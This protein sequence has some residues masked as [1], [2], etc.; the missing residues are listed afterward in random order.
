[1]ENV[2]VLMSTYNG[3][4][5]IE[6]QI[7]SILKQKDVNVFLYV[8]DDGSSDATKSILDRY[9]SE[10]KLKWYTGK[11]LKSSK[12]FM[13]LIYSVPLDSEFYALSDQDDFWLED[14]L[15]VAIKKIKSYPKDEPCLYYGKTLLVD[16]NLKRIEQ[17]PTSYVAK[18]MRQAI[19]SS[20][21]TG[22]TACFNRKLID[23]LR[24]GKFNFDLMHD[25]WIH[26]VCSALGGNLY[27][28]EQP[29]MLYRQHG[30]N[31]IG[32]Q[33]SA[34]KRLKRHVNTAVKNKC[35]RS[36]SIISLYKA[37]KEYMPIEN[38]CACEEILNYHKGLNR[39]KIVFDNRYRLG[40]KRLDCIFIGAVLLGVF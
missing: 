34:W 11:N 35:Y 25:N 28:D 3:E 18:T 27:Y 36:N 4:K 22:C 8:R 39:L 21:C 6:Q 17:Y 19:I 33:S 29:H 7:E 26:K 24:V 5:Y 9:Q 30:N 2:T 12:S 15:S 32:G 10:G 23:Y 14:K 40:D 16:E 20:G 37:Y 1:M 31:V 38:R 13:D